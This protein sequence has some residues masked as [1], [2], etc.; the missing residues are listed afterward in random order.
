MENNKVLNHLMLHLFVSQATAQGWKEFIYG[1]MVPTTLT[2]PKL[3][4]F[5]ESNN[6][7]AKPCH[8]RVSPTLEEGIVYYV[9]P[10]CR[11]EAFKSCWAR[12][13]LRDSCSTTHTHNTPISLHGLNRYNISDF[14]SLARVLSNFHLSC[15]SKQ[16]LWSHPDSYSANSNI[17]NQLENG[18]NSNT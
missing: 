11:G 15:D 16:I 7:L 4:N 6:P 3:L 2:L 10:T 8:M 1:R 13:M 18:P 17:Y 12:Y 5:L 9:S 14:M